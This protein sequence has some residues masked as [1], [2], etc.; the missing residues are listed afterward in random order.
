MIQDHPAFSPVPP[1]AGIL[2]SKNDDSKE[3]EEEEKEEDAFDEFLP[4]SIPP[5]ESLNTSPLPWLRSSHARQERREKQLR[6]KRRLRNLKRK[7]RLELVLKLFREV[8]GRFRHVANASIERRFGVDNRARFDCLKK[9]KIGVWRTRRLIVNR[10]TSKIENVKQG[11]LVW[12]K[13]L[14]SDVQ[15]CTRVDSVHIN[16]DFKSK[17]RTYKLR[18]PTVEDTDFFLKIM[19]YVQDEVSSVQ[20]RRSRERATTLERQASNLRHVSKPRVVSSRLDKNEF[21]AR[22][23]RMV[24]VAKDLSITGETCTQ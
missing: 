21:S 12:K 11:E 8:D 18:F 7:N 16:I 4:P 1:S 10:T 23:V 17:Q 5:P 9:D 13:I 14:I 20:E 2:I 6:E 3:E 15:T 24:F 19:N 22:D